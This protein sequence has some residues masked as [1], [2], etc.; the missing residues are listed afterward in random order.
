MS[1]P[2]HFYI[3]F[4]LP[5]VQTPQVKTGIDL[6][7]VIQIENHKSFKLFYESEKNPIIIFPLYVVYNI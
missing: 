3:A 4:F 7:N 6:T 1:P 5:F 2:D